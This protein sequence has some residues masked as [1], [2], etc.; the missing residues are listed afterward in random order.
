MGHRHS[1]YN[2]GAAIE[3]G[4]A[5]GTVVGVGTAAVAHV[6]LGAGRCCWARGRGAMA[7]GVAARVGSL[8]GAGQR[9]ANEQ[10]SE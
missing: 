7:G 6:D 10:S 9:G 2:V 4:A 1:I 5:A 8:G 3:A